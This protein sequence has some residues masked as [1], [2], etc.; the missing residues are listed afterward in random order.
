M[1]WSALLLCILEVPSSILSLE[2]G[3]LD[4]VLPAKCLDSINRPW[5]LQYTFF[6]PIS[7]LCLSMLCNIR[8]WKSR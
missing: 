2:T 7:S 3:Y 5:M 8:S 6:L 1:L 4:P